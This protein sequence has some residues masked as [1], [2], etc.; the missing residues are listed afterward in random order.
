MTHSF[1]V[2]MVLELLRTVDDELFS[3]SVAELLPCSEPALSDTEL[4]DSFRSDTFALL[5][6][7]ESSCAGDVLDSSSPQAINAKHIRQMDNFFIIIFLLCFI[8]KYRKLSG[9]DAVA[10][11]VPQVVYVAAAKAQSAR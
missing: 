11:V 6:D 7:S 5:E 9:H 1:I 2:G 8:T 3:L 10:N 4:D